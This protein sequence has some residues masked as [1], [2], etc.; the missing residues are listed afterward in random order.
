M[1]TTANVSVDEAMRTPQFYLLWL[2]LCLNVTAGIGVLGVAKTMMT[3][4][5]GTTLPAIVDS[6]FA[7][8]YVLAISVFNMAG[9]FF[10]ASVSDHIGR[11]STYTIFFVL[12]I[13]LYLSIPLCAHQVSASPSVVWLVYF[14]TATLL[15]FSMYGGGFAT[16][17]A[18]LS[19]MFGTQYVGAIHGRSLLAWSAAGVLGPLAITWL[20]EA[21]LTTATLELATNVDPR[22]FHETF[23]AG[24]ESL[25]ALIAAKTVTIAKLMEIAPAGAIDPS[26]SLYNSTMFLMAALLVVALVANLLVRPVDPKHHLDAG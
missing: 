24:V 16:L 2:V 7:A 17:P 9:R 1:I 25:D 21:S 11:K 23:G 8:S 22:V 6:S 20:R 18:Y 10:W 15:I 19:D 3:E 26:S 12:Q 13:V 4:I 5:F 14:Y